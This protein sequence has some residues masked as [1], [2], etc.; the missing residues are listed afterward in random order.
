MNGLRHG[1]GKEYYDN[2]KIKYEGEFLK[3]EKWN[4]KRYDKNGNVLYEIENGKGCIKEYDSYDTLIF[5]GEYSDGFINGK[6]KENDY[7]GELRF[8]GEYL[9]VKKIKGKEYINRK[10]EYEGE[11]L[12]DRKWNGNGYDEKVI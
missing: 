4:I 12:F 3:G 7:Y 6:G 9:Y 11:Y 1:I 2:G 5:E 8:E 10:L